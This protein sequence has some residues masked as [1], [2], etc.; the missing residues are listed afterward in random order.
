MHKATASGFS[1]WVFR[2]KKRRWLAAADAEF[3]EWNRDPARRRGLIDHA[4][5]DALRQRIHNDLIGEPTS[6]HPIFADN[7]STSGHVFRASALTVGGRPL[8]CR[9]DLVLKNEA[10]HHVVIV[11]R[12]TTRQLR[13]LSQ[14]ETSR[15]NWCNIQAQ[16]WCYSHVDD[17]NDEKRVTL[18]GEIWRRLGDDQ[19]VKAIDPFVWHKGDIEHESKCKALFQHYGGRV[20]GQVVRLRSTD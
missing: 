8:A 12:K 3:S 9:P 11:E 15:G 13:T 1:D 4:E 14:Q 20:E 7:E 18:I 19:L 2:F 10:K 17:W 5:I 16:L 6:Y